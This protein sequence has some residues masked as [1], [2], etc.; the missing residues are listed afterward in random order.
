MSY[1]LRDKN[2]GKYFVRFVDDVPTWA[3]DMAL[4]HSYEKR[5]SGDADKLA[6]LNYEIQI[7]NLEWEQAAIIARESGNDTT[8]NIKRIMR[9]CKEVV[10]NGYSMG[11]ALPCWRWLRTREEFPIIE[12]RISTV[13]KGSPVYLE[14]YKVA[15]VENIPPVYQA[16]AHDSYVLKHAAELAALGFVYRA[17]NMPLRLT[18]E[19]LVDAGLKGAK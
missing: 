16:T 18:T 3:D 5:K 1:I 17:E 6:E 8:P 15:L 11:I 7:L 14:Q 12:A 2:T 19:K 9:E 10:D 4:S 13:L